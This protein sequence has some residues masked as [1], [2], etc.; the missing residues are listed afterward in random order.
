MAQNREMEHLF[1]KLYV[2]GEENHVHFFPRSVFLYY[3]LSQDPNQW[4]QVLK[5]YI[6]MDL[7]YFCAD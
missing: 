7:Q 2:S 4:M 5:F 1:V 6:F 3:M